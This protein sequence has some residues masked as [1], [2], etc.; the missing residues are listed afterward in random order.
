MAKTTKRN[1][2]RAKKANGDGALSEAG[3]RLYGAE[4]HLRLMEEVVAVLA[5][6]MRKEL[7]GATTTLREARGDNE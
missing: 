6:V 1:N 7:N 5:S 2:G 3:Y 4:R